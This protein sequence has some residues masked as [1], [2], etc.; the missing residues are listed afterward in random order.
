MGAYHK[1]FIQKREKTHNHIG[2][3]IKVSENR[4]KRKSAVL[5]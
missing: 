4:E 5:P 1:S 3:T 2:K